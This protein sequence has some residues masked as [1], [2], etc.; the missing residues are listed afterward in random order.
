MRPVRRCVAMTAQV[1]AIAGGK[2]GV[3]KTTTTLNVAAALAA[4]GNSVVAVDVDLAMANLGQMLGIEADDGPTV[5]DVLAGD[6]DI[7]ET[8]HETEFGFDVVPGTQKLEGF[9]NA[10]PAR[11][12]SAVLD[13]LRDRYDVVLMDTSAGLSH[14]V[15][16]PL[17]LADSVLLITTADVVAIKDAAKTGELTSRV[18]GRVEGVVLTRARD[19]EATEQIIEELGDQ[20]LAVIPEDGRI[21]MNAPVAAAE[22]QTAAAYSGLAARLFGKE[23]LDETAGE[24]SGGAT[25]EDAVSSV[26]AA[27]KSQATTHAERAERA[28][29]DSPTPKRAATPGSLTPAIRK[30][31]EDELAE[32]EESVDPVVDGPVTTSSFDEERDRQRG[33]SFF[34]D[35]VEDE[36]VDEEE[37]EERAGALGRLRD[38]LG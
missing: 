17:G 36:G 23:A 1:H 19:N 16:V 9:A 13:P 4:A 31:S 33:G 29:E 5:H 14:E 28:G 30:L 7:D 11:L 21:S 20:V 37:R 2:G 35:P 27:R 6:A 12:R 26:E 38:I 32:E 22:S 3:G 18:D 34:G 15:T 10:D 24:Y 8:V 25:A